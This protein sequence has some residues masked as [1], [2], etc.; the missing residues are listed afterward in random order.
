MKS[1]LPILLLALLS[2]CAAINPGEPRVAQL[3]GTQLGLHQQTISWPTDKW[4]QRYDDPQLNRLI[5]E[6]LVGS[7]SL[8]AAQARLDVANAAVGGAR[9]VQLPQLNANYTMLRERFSANYIRSEERRV[10]KACVST[11]RSRWSP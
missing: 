3:D 8:A 5:D 6:A 4:W 11:C 2:G 7:P 1:L 9:A 10:G